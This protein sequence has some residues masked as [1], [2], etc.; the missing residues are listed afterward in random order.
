MRMHALGSAVLAFAMAASVLSCALLVSFDDYDLDAVAATY[1]VGGTVEGLTGDELVTLT[2][3]GGAPN[4]VRG[5]P[6]TFPDK[7]PDGVPYVVAV[8]AS[9]QGHTC[10][11]RNRGQGVIAKGDIRDLTVQCPL[12]DATLT[13]VAVNGQRLAP[14][15]DPM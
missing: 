4:L 15:V 13:S 3:N 2:L 7:L 5:G 9:P 10:V 14:T 8:T 6:F 11:V 1:G 12:T